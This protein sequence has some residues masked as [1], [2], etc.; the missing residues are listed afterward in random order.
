[1]NKSKFFGLLMIMTLIFSGIVLAQNDEPE[2]TATLTGAAEVPGP[3]D[4]DGTG[5]AMIRLNKNKAEAC[6]EISVENIDAATAAHIH[7]AP[8]GEAGPPVV[9]L[10]PAPKDEDGEESESD[11]VSVD[12]L[13]VER[14]IMNPARFYVNVHN[15]EFPDGAIRGQLSMV[16]A[17]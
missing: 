11:C 15:A 13:L 5:T 2:F 6:F 7:E 8:E 3:G 16:K 1:M 4:S 10:S 12:P 14:I 17:D 9:T